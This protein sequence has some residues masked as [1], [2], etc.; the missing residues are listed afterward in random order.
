MPLVSVLLPV[1]NA[2]HDLPR[3]IR[4]LREQT[5]SD[6]EVVAIDD[7]STDGSAE[8]LDHYAS[9]D[10]RLRVFHQPNAGALGKALNRAAELAGGRYLARQDADDASA[11]TR[12]EEQ[13][14]YLD[15]HPQVGL[16]GAWNWQI[17]SQ[18]GPLFSSELPDDHARL[19]HFLEKGMNPFVHGSVM[20]RADLFRKTGGYRGSLV[21]DFDLW[22]R[23]SEITRLGM[24]EK[25]GYYYWRSAGGI[26][27]G[28]HIR[29]QKLVKL[30]LKLHE[31]RLH[32]GQEVTAWESEY[33]LIINAHIA[34][35]SPDERKT[36]MHYARSIHLMRLGRWEAARSELVLAAAGQGQYARKASRNLSF[37]RFAPLV[38]AVYRLI[39]TQELQRYAKT[40]PTGTPL[41]EFLQS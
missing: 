22:L 11:L 26:S 2:S 9:L 41:P 19:L 40:L 16:C 34:E 24:C 13:A 38:G 20:M 21:E 1:Y 30:A 23:M 18:L 27:S 8:L 10:Q 3:V 33:Q 4:S 14:R 17:D 31:E 5:L 25:L 7:G 35:A 6:F 29:Q 28:A 39:E 36:S 32:V 12:L 37:F 15:T